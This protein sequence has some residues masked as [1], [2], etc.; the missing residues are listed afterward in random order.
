MA[1]VTAPARPT[2]GDLWHQIASVEHPSLLLV[3]AVV[4]LPALWPLLGLFFPARR[5]RPAEDDGDSWRYWDNSDDALFWFLLPLLFPL[6]RLAA[7]LALYAL[8]VAG[9][10]WLLLQI[11]H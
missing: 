11:V 8:L 6:L 1:L 10:Y 5:Y 4:S 3:A 7:L 9:V 2:I